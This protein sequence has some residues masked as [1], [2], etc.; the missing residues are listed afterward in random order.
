MHKEY[1]YILFIHYEAFIYTNNEETERET[2]ETI[3]FTIAT[4]KILRNKPKGTKDLYIESHKT[5]I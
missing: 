4:T 3:P 1:F 5:L 2:K